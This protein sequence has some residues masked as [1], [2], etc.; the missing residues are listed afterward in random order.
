MLP[1]IVPHQR[2]DDGFFRSFDPSIPKCRQF[3]WIPL[4]SQNRID[5]AEARDIAD[6]VMDL[7]VH[8]I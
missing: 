7:Q 8:L 2:F 5:D 1:A 6:D 4:A 3:C